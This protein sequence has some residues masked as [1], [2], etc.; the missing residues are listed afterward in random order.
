VHPPHMK[1]LLG[2]WSVDPRD[3]R[4]FETN[5]HCITEA[6]LDNLLESTARY[7][8]MEKRLSKTVVRIAD[9]EINGRPCDRV[10]TI[11]REGDRRLFYGYHCVLWLDKIT[12]LPVGAETYDWPQ[13]SNAGMCDLLESYRYLY[14][15]CNIGLTD[16]VFAH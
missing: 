12:H 14:L 9:D 3:P 7:W 15:R 4:A 16:R 6:G 5:R 8:D 10:E 1:G 2:F 13:A 11:H